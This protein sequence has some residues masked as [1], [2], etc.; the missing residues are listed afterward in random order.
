MCVYVCNMYVCIG[1]MRK[2]IIKDRKKNMRI[3]FWEVTKSH[4]K[5]GCD[6][7]ASCD[8]RDYYNNNK[9]S[10]VVGIFSFYFFNALIFLLSRRSKIVDPR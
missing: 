2:I 10:S 3:V 9:Y 8:L 1:R 7:M 6:K 5:K 4:W